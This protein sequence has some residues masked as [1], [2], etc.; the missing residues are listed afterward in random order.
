MR[1]ASSRF[2]ADIFS[3]VSIPRGLAAPQVGVSKR[4]VVCGL[5]GDLKVMINPRI[6]EKRGTYESSEGCLSLRTG[7]VN[8]VNRPAYIKF[9]Y[10]DLD[11]RERILEV[12]NRDAALIEHEIDHLDG[13]LNVD[14]LAD[15]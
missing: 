5:H 15:K 11:N 3:K 10:T 14:Y 6:L 12:R 13:V 7:K 4:L 2:A 9:Q 1:P 8:Q